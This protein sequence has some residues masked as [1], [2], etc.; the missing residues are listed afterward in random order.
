MDDKRLDE[1]GSGPEASRDRQEQKPGGKEGWWK[2]DP[3]GKES[4]LDHPN[5]EPDNLKGNDL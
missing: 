1:A 2:K 4:E 5:M 3:A